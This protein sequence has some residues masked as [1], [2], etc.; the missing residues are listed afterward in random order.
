MF[1]KI[2]HKYGHLSTGGDI[3]EDNAE[4]PYSRSHT[5]ETL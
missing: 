1:V 5:I 3:R 4:I 2:R